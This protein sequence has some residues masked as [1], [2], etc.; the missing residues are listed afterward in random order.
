MYTKSMTDDDIVKLRELLKKEQQISRES[1]PL[2]RA[3]LLMELD[4]YRQVQ[5]KMW[6]TLKKT[7]SQLKIRYLYVN[8]NELSGCEKRDYNG[9][10]AVWKLCRV[11]NIEGGCGNSDQHQ[12]AFG[13]KYFD[14]SKIG[15]WNLQEDRLLQPEER[16]NLRFNLVVNR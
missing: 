4:E 13:G 5:D 11:L 6:D 8:N 12:L 9:W 15:F 2:V 16:T 10:P 3:C 7:A 1:C 14:D